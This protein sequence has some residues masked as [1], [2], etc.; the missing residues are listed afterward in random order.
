VAR[1]DWD[2][3][4]ILSQSLVGHT[5]PGRFP[6]PWHSPAWAFRICRPLLLRDAGP[7]NLPVRLQQVHCN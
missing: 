2:I 1:G 5:P 4:H 7:Q 6:W 3:S